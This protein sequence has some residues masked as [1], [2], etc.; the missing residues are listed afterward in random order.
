MKTVYLIFSVYLLSI[1]CRRD[2]SLSPNLQRCTFS[3]NEWFVEREIQHVE[4]TV[5]QDTLEMFVISFEDR[6]QTGWTGLVAC[7][8]P[9]SFKISNRK[10]EISGKI[11]SHPRMDYRYAPIELTSI[12]FSN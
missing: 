11:Y 5:V 1:S 2:T 9:D 12:R 3:D 7:N 8:M 10:V 4:G 6:Q